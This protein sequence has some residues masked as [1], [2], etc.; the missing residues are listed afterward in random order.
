MA[1]FYVT[2]KQTR[3]IRK[4]ETKPMEHAKYYKTKQKH[5]GK[6]EKISNITSKH[7]N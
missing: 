6:I 2:E 4:I 1:A 7:N 3:L 5:E